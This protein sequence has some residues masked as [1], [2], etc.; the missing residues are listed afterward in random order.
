VPLRTVYEY[1]L[2]EECLLEAQALQPHL[3]RLGTALDAV[4]ERLATAPGTEAEALQ[5]E[6]D[7]LRRTLPS[8]YGRWEQAARGA[9]PASTLL[10][11]APTLDAMRH[12]IEAAHGLDK[13]CA[14]T[15]W[16][17]LGRG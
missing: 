6:A 15:F 5:A 7:Q 9:A 13:V 14:P 10:R 1:L 12:E 16:V 17:R 8:D 2:D 11:R 4:L 3:E